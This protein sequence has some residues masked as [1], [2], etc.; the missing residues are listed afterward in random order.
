M[1]FRCLVFFPLICTLVNAQEIKQH[2][3]PKALSV[4]EELSKRVPAKS[5]EIEIEKINLQK[6]IQWLEALKQYVH[7]NRNGNKFFPYDS[8]I[9]HL[10]N[11]LESLNTI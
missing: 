1:K 7:Y 9:K 4:R 11:K 8:K 10:K 5:S 2:V 3:G 6:R